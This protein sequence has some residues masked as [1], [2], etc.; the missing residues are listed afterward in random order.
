MKTMH[1]GFG[2]LAV[3]TVAIAAFSGP[4]LL[5]NAPQPAAPAAPAAPA[6]KAAV[7][8]V[9]LSVSGMH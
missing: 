7:K 6:Q 5:G 8:S 1:L 2:T 9:L 3:A 4:A